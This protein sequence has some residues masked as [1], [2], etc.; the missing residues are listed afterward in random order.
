MKKKGFTLIELLAVIVILAIIAVIATPIVL[1]IIEK[2]KLKS[3]EIAANN[4]IKAVELYRTE[5]EIANNVELINTTININNKQIEGN[6]FNLSGELP[7]SGFIYINAEGKIGV[8][9]YKDGLCIKRKTFN[10]KILVYNRKKENCNLDSINLFDFNKYVDAVFGE[11][12]SLTKN[13]L[14][15]SYIRDTQ[16]FILD[17]E[18]T[19]DNTAFTLRDLSF[20]VDGEYT[21]SIRHIGG[22]Y[23]CNDSDNFVAFANSTWS[24]SLR[25]YFYSIS[26]D[27]SSKSG[28]F[29]NQVI[30]HFVQIRSDIGSIF[31]QFKF[32]IQFEKGKKPTEFEL[33]GI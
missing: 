15:L 27:L 32:K 5:Y 17:G 12:L 26:N 24:S 16:E 13:G 8:A 11:N 2:S 25:T 18:A 7:E 1:N 4:I 33:F 29:S 10:D 21:L 6:L 9:L 14:T 28:T 22:T 3:L 31:N 30:I 23:S 19:A 20:A